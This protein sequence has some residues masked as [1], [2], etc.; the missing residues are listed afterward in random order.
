MD[1]PEGFGDCPFPELTRGGWC[2][3]FVLYPFH[4][5]YLLIHVL[6]TVAVTLHTLKN[7][8]ISL[9]GTLIPGFIAVH[10]FTLND[11]EFWFA[12]VTDSLVVNVAI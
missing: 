10:V 12:G 9:N 5:R 6:V 7:A 3:S 4:K 1:N 8:T 11:S 2:V